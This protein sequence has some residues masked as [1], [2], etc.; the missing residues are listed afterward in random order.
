M[1][2][3]KGARDNGALEFRIGLVS[4]RWR[5]VLLPGCGVLSKPSTE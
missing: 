4:L 1:R 3:M 2:S 5:S